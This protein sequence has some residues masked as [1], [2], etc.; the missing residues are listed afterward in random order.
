MSAPTTIAVLGA[1][2]WG[3]AL[4]S[5]LAR[6]DHR[7]RLWGRDAS[8]VQAMQQTRINQRYLPQYT[9]PDNL[10]CEPDLACCIQDCNA[11]LLA[12]PSGA[13]PETLAQ[14]SAMGQ[15]IDILIWACKGLYLDSL[16]CDTFGAE[17]KKGLISGPSFA[18]E[19]MQGLPTAVTVTAGDTKTA[20]LIASWLSCGQFYVHTCDDMLGVQIGGALKNVF[21]I[22]VGMADGLALGY[23]ARAALIS[24]SLSE[25]VQL[26]TA[27]GARNETLMGLSGLGDMVLSC[28]ADHSRNRRLGLALA[29]GQSIAD[30]RR[31]IGQVIEGID[32]VKIARALAARHGVAMPIAEQVYQVLYE[33]KTPPDALGALFSTPR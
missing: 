29:Q 13:L 15:P 6:S 28:T 31:N 7:V 5:H 9:L 25:L 11:V 26:G 32:A 27:M 20:Q 30:A 1:G 22:A 24:R 14:L 19:V 18:V 33:H 12:V 10:L 8:A 16:I 21:A 17:Q 4:A 2:S 3:T 23:N